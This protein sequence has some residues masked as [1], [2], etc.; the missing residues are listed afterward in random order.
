MTH[1]KSFTPGSFCWADLSTTDWQAAKRF[2]TALFGWNIEERSMG[3]GRPPY[4]MLK[5]GDA[6]VAAL[7]QQDDEQRLL[8]VPASWLAYFMVADADAATAAARELGA[9]VVLGPFDV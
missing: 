1:V 3:R 7:Y 2:Y 9:N 4:V 5:K 6:M 8:E